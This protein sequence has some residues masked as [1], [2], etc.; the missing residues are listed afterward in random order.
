M[1][2]HISGNVPSYLGAKTSSG[3]GSADSSIM[4]PRKPLAE[5]VDLA[6]I[7]SWNARQRLVIE[8]YHRKMAYQELSPEEKTTK[9][10]RN[11]KNG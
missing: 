7:A 9:R 2:V 6:A 5:R 11:I 3:H 8:S 4:A 10:G 1:G